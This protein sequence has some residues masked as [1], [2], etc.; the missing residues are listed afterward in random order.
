MGAATLAFSDGATITPA[1]DAKLYRVARV[2]DGAW[3]TRSAFAAEGVPVVERDGAAVNSLDSWPRIPPGTGRLDSWE[4]AR[5]A[6]PRIPAEALYLYGGAPPL[7]AL[8]FTFVSRGISHRGESASG[9]GS[10]SYEAEVHAAFGAP[11]AFVLPLRPGEDGPHGLQF[12]DVVAT[13]ARGAWEVA[14]V[15]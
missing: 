6:E 11:G 4:L 12:G 3:N 14:V 10:V 9:P 7:D 1:P 8:T 15:R 2:A 13:T 5:V